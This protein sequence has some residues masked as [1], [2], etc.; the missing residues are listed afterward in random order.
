MSRSKLWLSLSLF[1]LMA[2]RFK[3]QTSS[4]YL[5]NLCS[6]FF[7][8]LSDLHLFICAR[9]PQ[10]LSSVLFLLANSFLSDISSLEFRFL[11]FRRRTVYIQVGFAIRFQ[12]CATWIFNPST[13]GANNTFAENNASK[14]V[15]T[16]HNVVRSLVHNH[17]RKYPSA[18][19]YYL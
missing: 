6:G 14:F 13:I 15:V 4:Y 2:Y 19:S 8:W 16:V 17:Q 9:E 12:N 11:L 18:G 10:L 5:A 1:P 3:I 7:S